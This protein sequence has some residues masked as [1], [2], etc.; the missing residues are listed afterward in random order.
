[1]HVHPFHNEATQSSQNNKRK[2]QPIDQPLH[3]GKLTDPIIRIVFGRRERFDGKGFIKSENNSQQT[4]CTPDVGQ[5]DYLV[6]DILP[7]SDMES[8]LFEV[9]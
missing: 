7:V 6:G 9:C 8:H 2:R 4:A 5:L 1:M 3:I